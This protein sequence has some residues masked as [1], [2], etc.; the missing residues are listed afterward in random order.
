MCKIEGIVLWTKIDAPP[1]FLTDRKAE[2]GWK[3]LLRDNSL[4]E[5]FVGLIQVSVKN[6]IRELFWM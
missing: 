5:K 2:Y 6:M 1:P 3:V 4:S